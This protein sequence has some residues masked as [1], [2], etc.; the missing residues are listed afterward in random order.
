MNPTRIDVLG[1]DYFVLSLS[2]LAT[3]S[4]DA[5]LTG[6]RAVHLHPS[7]TADFFVRSYS[8]RGRQCSNDPAAAVSAA[9]HLSL[10]RGLPL[11]EFLFET[12]RGFLKISCTGDGFFALTLQKCKVLFT[13]FVET[14]GC[15]VKYCDVS[16]GGVCR[17]VLAENIR[18]ADTLALKELLTAGRH[19]PSAILFASLDGSELEILPYTDF[20]PSPPS[21]IELYAAAALAFHNRGREL[22]ALDGRLLLCAGCSDVSLKIKCELTE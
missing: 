8:K 6:E 13:D 22:R 1:E 14:L 5:I 21:L 9:A 15:T 12:P 18:A 10:K 20:N 11:D 16:A 3:E 17:V 4:D 2:G 19:L 7:L